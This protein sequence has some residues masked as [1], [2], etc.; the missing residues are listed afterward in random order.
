[1]TIIV[2]HY[3]LREL[4]S[5]TVLAFR[6]SSQQQYLAFRKSTPGLAFPGSILGSMLNIF[7]VKIHGAIHVANPG[8]I[9]G[10]MLF[11]TFFW[12]L[13]WALYWMFFWMLIQ[14]LIGMIIVMLIV[15]LIGTLIGML[16]EMLI[17]IQHSANF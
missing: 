7:L 14:T 12:R 6:K 10:A 9:Y 15:T 8:L 4:N 13:F 3:I 11:I 17:S 16:I 2:K 5:T 1:M